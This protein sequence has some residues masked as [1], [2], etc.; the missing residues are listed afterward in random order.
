MS[1]DKTESIAL[2]SVISFAFAILLGTTTLIFNKLP[3]VMLLWGVM[4]GMVLGH[5]EVK[6]IH[7]ILK[8]AIIPSAVLCLAPTIMALLR[9][10]LAAAAG[11]MPD[12][13]NFM[14]YSIFNPGWWH[15][16][17]GT[18]S[19]VLLVS[20]VVST[21]ILTGCSLASGRIQAHLSTAYAAG[22]EAFERVEKI[23]K[24][25]LAIGSVVGVYLFVQ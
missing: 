4:A 20:F 1:P 7:A 19:A 10:L 13:Q 15:S 23:L 18:V 12:V 24:R 6:R 3:L 14:G 5:Q 16:K 17:P 11:V 9:A 25:V 8:L 2:A 22:P 21:V